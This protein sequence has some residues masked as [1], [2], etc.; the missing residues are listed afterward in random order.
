MFDAVD[1]GGYASPPKIRV[2]HSS[3]L[4]R[5]EWDPVD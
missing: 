3:Q 2:P 1:H 4:Y 5:D